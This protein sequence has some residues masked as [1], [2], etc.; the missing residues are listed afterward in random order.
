MSPAEAK[1]TAHKFLRTFHATLKGQ[2]RP[3]DKMEPFIRQTVKHAKPLHA[4]R[5]LRLPE[6]AFL[7]TF[8][9]PDLADA[10]R[11]GAGLTLQE[12]REAL[13][14]EY[15]PSMSDLSCGSPARRVKHPF[16]KVLSLGVSTNLL[17][18]G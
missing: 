7:D 4:E 18:M 12:A 3:A 16:T 11:T 17:Q 13:L 2:L 10:I 14:N 5:H 1:D 8:V 9:I 6:S 15:H